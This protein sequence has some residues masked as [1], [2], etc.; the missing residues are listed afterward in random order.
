[1]S[2][3][4]SESDSQIDSL[5]RNHFF[6]VAFNIGTAAPYNGPLHPFEVGGQ[7]LMQHQGGSSPAF[8]GVAGSDDSRSP[9]RQTPRHRTVVPGCT[10][11]KTPLNPSSAGFRRYSAAFVT[12][13]SASM[14][15]VYWM[16]CFLMATPCR[17]CNDR[18]CLG[19]TDASLRHDHSLLSRL[20]PP[21]ARHPGATRG[22]ANH[23]RMSSRIDRRPAVTSRSRS[24]VE[25]PRAPVRYPAGV[26]FGPP[27]PSG[28]QGSG[29]PAPLLPPRTHPP[30]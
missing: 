10:G 23:S 22:R 11:Q 17:Y 21:G 27:P 26:R 7:R 6:H 14:G 15:D 5:R 4:E 16:V 8:D 29:R 25:R 28:L 1:M 2:L 3:F 18:L 30:V 9:N 19:G 13:T 20:A 12:A 24:I